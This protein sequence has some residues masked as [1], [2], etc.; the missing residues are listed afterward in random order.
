MRLFDVVGT[1]F[2]SYYKAV[3][4]FL[5]MFS[6]DDQESYNTLE[7]WVQDIQQHNPKSLIQI[8]ANKSDKPVAIRYD[9]QRWLCN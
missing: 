3:D 6:L 9:I 4:G 2:P 7:G 5:L 1:I 8:I